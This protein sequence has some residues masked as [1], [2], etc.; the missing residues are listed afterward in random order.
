MRHRTSVV[1][2]RGFTVYLGLVTGRNFGLVAAKPNSA[3]RK[4]GIAVRLRNRGFLQKWQCPATGP[5]EN[6][7]GSDILLLSSFF[8]PNLHTPQVP[9]AV[10][11]LHSTAKVN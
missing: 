10:Q 4:P 3:D 6:E 5:D 11:I 9:I 7:F 8:I 2:P 1:I